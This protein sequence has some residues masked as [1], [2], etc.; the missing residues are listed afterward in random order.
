[1]ENCGIY[2]SD[3]TR[4]CVKKI[5]EEKNLVVCTC[6]IWISLECLQLQLAWSNL[7]LSARD[8]VDNGVC[9]DIISLLDKK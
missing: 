6:S 3:C 5:K 2:S 1:M 9:Q 4:L 7:M 8:A